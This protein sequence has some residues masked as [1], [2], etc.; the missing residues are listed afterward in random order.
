MESNCSIKG[1]PVGG[2][3]S[4]GW[5]AWESDGDDE[6]AAKRFA[7]QRLME[8]TGPEGVR[9][10]IF[11]KDRL[12]ARVRSAFVLTIWGRSSGS[13]GTA[14]AIET[15]WHP[16]PAWQFWGSIFLVGML[17]ALPPLLRAAKMMR[18]RQDQLDAET[19][20]GERR[21]THR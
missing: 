17:A 12:G 2:G 15:L 18:S 14:V 16:A 20:K 10:E 4:I 11:I 21:V 7:E 8:A 5:D 9:W 3:Y 1:F 6:A 13:L 19:R